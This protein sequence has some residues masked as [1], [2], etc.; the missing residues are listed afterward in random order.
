MIQQYCFRKEQLSTVNGRVNHVHLR[1]R[2]YCNEK[3]N[4]RLETVYAAGVRN[5]QVGHSSWSLGIKQQLICYH[6][7]GVLHREGIFKL[8]NTYLQTIRDFRRNFR[9]WG[10]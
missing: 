10:Q 9:I 8:Q 6:D 5:W 2:P 4:N 1:R 7:Q 3:T